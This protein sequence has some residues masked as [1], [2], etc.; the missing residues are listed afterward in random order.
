MSLTTG[1]RRQLLQGCGLPLPEQVV[2]DCT[3]GESRNP[4]DAAHFGLLGV[5]QADRVRV[6][7]TVRIA[8]IVTISIRV[9]AATFLGA[10]LVFDT[11]VS[12]LISR[13]IDDEHFLA[14]DQLGTRGTRTKLLPLPTH[15]IA[16]QQGRHLCQRLDDF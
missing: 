16:R 15:D 1:W 6:A 12:R 4:Y 2:L 11:T 8:G 10:G 14:V 3:L 5:G 9:Q 7:D 13:L